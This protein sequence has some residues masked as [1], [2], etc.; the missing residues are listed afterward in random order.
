MHKI[1]DFI[2]KSF[3]IWVLLLLLVIFASN[4][5][6]D[7]FN[8]RFDATFDRSYSFSEGTKKLIK[9]I[10]NPLEIR[11][12]HSTSSKSIPL[13]I[14]NFGKR[15]EDVLVEF[16]NRSDGKIKLLS[17]DPAPDSDEEL[18][19]VQSG[20]AANPLGS[21]N[22]F[23][24]AL[25][26]Y[27]EKEVTVEVFDPARERFLE[28]DISRTI[29]DLLVDKK[30]TI[31]VLSSINV[32]G[33]DANPFQAATPDKF[34]ISELKKTYQVKSLDYGSTLSIPD[35]IETLLVFHPQA[36]KDNVKYAVDQ[37][38]LRGGK[39][40]MVF[41]P[42]MRH[43]PQA[44]S[45]RGQ[46]QEHYISRSMPKKFFDS[47]GVEY[48]DEVVF[49]DR[50]FAAIVQTPDG[51][52][53]YALWFNGNE[54][55]LNH[56]VAVTAGIKDLLFVE[57]G[58]FRLKSDATSDLELTSLVQSSQ[59]TGFVNIFVVSYIEIDKLN[60]SME[61]GDGEWDLMGILSGKFH[62]IFTKAPPL[63]GTDAT[64]DTLIKEHKKLSKHLA[65][66]KD[67]NRVLIVADADFLDDAVTVNRMRFFNQV[68][69]QPKNDNIG[70]FF[71]AISDL[72]GSEALSLIKPKSVN[73]RPFQLFIDMQRKAQGKYI[74]NEK[75]L[76]ARLEGLKSSLAELKPA[77][78]TSRIDIPPQ[79]LA[80]IEEYQTLELGIKKQL[81][82]IR[83]LLR[84]DIELLKNILILLNL[85][86]VPIIITFIGVRTY[87][88][89]MQRT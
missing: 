72:Q 75:K 61:K 10:E 19:A 20:V 16:A 88:K 24:G 6:F 43:D 25:F 27:G 12:Y 11:F 83:K 85:F 44:S 70:L 76:E 52:F 42:Y 71:S 54:K 68:I 48:K 34:F 63:S 13:P 59:D 65:V 82:E 89:R 79:T 86:F 55:S 41:D 62:S 45:P 69:N 56:D 17:Y 73:A 57:P 77:Q 14:K 8:I 26:S 3:T 28:Y 9:T 78:G 49:G 58:S 84:E 18:S 7:I 87:M 30:A 2:S 23:L 1:L 35:D 53:P 32:F 37:F 31:G 38:M 36:M 80:K 50:E 64:N 4:Y 33:Q 21:E 81:R 40:V 29:Y 46:S 51:Q 74:E 5:I 22:Y 66:G 39:L 60:S 47:W 15:V 67:D